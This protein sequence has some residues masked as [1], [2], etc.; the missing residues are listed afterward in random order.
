MNKRAAGRGDRASDPGLK[1]VLAQ[2]PRRGAEKSTYALAGWL[3]HNIQDNGSQAALKWGT[4]G[5]PTYVGTFKAI[6]R[7]TQ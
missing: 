4:Y 5:L 1:R 2:G 7:S 3:R 6:G